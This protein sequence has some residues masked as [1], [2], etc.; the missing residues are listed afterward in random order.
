[1]P[2]SVASVEIR[3]TSASMPETTQGKQ[4]MSQAAN[5]LAEPTIELP[6]SAPQVRITAGFG[7]AGQKT[8]NLRRPVTLVGSKRPAHIVLHDR[9]ISVAHCAIVNT[10]KDVL[11]FDLHTTNGTCRNKE[12]IELV[13]LNDGDVISIG[14]SMIQVAIRVPAGETD[15]SGCGMEF[16]EPTSLPQPITLSLIHAERSWK[17]ESAAALIGRH[18]KAGVRLDHT[19]ISMRH[20][21]IFRFG[22]GS[23]LYD[24][25]SRSGVWV[26]GRRC[27]M[28]PLSN[29]DRLTVGPFGLAVQMNESRPTP[30][31]GATTQSRAQSTPSTSVGAKPAVNEPTNDE[32]SVVEPNAGPKLDP[33][34]TNIAD[35]WQRLN[36]WR[37]QLQRDA[38][39]IDE[40]QSGLK[41][42]EAELDARDAALRG[43]LH[44]ITQFNDKLAQRERELFEHGARI[45]TEADALAVA[46]REAAERE[47]ELQK[48]IDEI[49]RRENALAQRWSRMQS[50]ICP[51]CQKPLSLGTG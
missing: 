39:H 4:T 41:T 3:L 12:K 23:A 8:W 36:Q 25:G 5:V 44:D 24:L 38:G 11:L 45:Q 18:E 40:Q 34:N 51:N 27:E 9:D 14:D 50:I 33:I 29:G 10:G 19:D 49:T 47:V 32:E 30:C 15:D 17:I 46:K 7:S 1:M 35:A 43:Q 2:Q 21:V 37:A 26:N 22:D 31:G 48:R 28:H 16:I 20:A 42:R 6:P 13:A